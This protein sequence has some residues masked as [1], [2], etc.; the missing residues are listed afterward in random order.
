MKKRLAV[1]SLLIVACAPLCAAQKSGERKSKYGEYFRQSDEERRSR[2]YVEYFKSLGGDWSLPAELN[3][4][5]EPA[6]LPKGKDA[7]VVQ[8]VTRGGFTG[9]G[10]G[11]VILTS[12][13]DL[14][15]SLSVFN[16]CANTLSPA[17]L[18]SLSKLVASANP[19]EWKGKPVGLCRDCYVSLLA[20]QRRDAKGRGESYKVHFD[21]TTLAQMP[22]EVRRLYA[23]AFELATPPM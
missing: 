12:D 17:A 8:I 2:E 16:S 3:G 13:G 22:E 6:K 10:R 7:W 14:R 4:A 5:F 20:L 23:R 9:R 21:D 1:A 18:E 19:K 15:C 11:D